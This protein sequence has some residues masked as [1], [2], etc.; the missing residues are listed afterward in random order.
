MLKSEMGREVVGPE[1][2]F[3]YA[4]VEINIAP[5]VRYPISLKTV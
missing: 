2:G 1:A 4:K 3:R 5:Y